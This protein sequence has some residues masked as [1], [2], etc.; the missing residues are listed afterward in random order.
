MECMWILKK[1][2]KRAK[3]GNMREDDERRIGEWN[4]IQF[5]NESRAGQKI[6]FTGKHKRGDENY[7]QN[8]SVGDGTW[9]S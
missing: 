7:L 9:D 8:C 3:A 4:V 1:G 5:S 2:K 6:V